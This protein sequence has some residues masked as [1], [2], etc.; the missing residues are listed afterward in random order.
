MNFLIFAGFVS[1]ISGIMLI[2]YPKAF[3][4]VARWSNKTAAN[5][6]MTILK[7]RIVIGICLILISAY[8]WFVTYYMKAIPLLEKMS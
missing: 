3:M 6:D 7:Y 2:L 4:A 8:L 1:L 5:I